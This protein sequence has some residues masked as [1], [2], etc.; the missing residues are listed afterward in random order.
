MKNK[1]QKRDNATCFLY[2]T[3][4]S[5]RFPIFV[6]SPPP[7]LRLWLRNL[8]ELTSTHLYA[9]RYVRGSGAQGLMPHVTSHQTLSLQSVRHS[10]L[11]MFGLNMEEKIL[12][13]PS[14]MSAGPCPHLKACPS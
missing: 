10:L 11:F 4:S 3:V 14:S 13:G 5:F 8:H 6:V 9:W 1:Q 7:I 2:E 12:Q